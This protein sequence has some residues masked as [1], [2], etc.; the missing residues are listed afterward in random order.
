MSGT[1]AVS[2]LITSYNRERFLGASIE[3][4]LAQWFSDFEV[5]LV[6]DAS[7]DGTLEVARAYAAVDSRVRVIENATRVGQFANRNR[8]AAVSRG[9]LIRFHDS[10]DLMYPHC[11]AVIVPPMLRQPAAA[12]G[13]SMSRAFAGGPVPMLLTPRHSFEREFFGMGMFTEGPSA[14]I[15]R[16]E[17]FLELGGFPDAGVASDTLFWIHACARENVLALPGD[18]YWYR[19][20]EGQELSGEDA[21]REYRRAVGEI[22]R[23]LDDPACPLTALE[24]KRAKRTIVS[25]LL[26]NTARDIRHR[27]LAAAFRRLTESGLSIRDVLTHCR[28]HQHSLLAGTPLSRNGEF[29]AP[30]WSLFEPPH[31]PPGDSNER[32]ASR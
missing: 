30:D 32:R 23:S 16:R 27:R 14:G 3:S 29:L 5:L 7:T 22:F 12:I 25:R 31:G 28:P 6:D 11:L 10:D 9:T 1:P 18:L 13:L 17:K 21:E 15:F 2:V 19:R 8:A 20:H 26:R 4:V 24:K